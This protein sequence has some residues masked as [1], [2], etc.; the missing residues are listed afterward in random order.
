MKIYIHNIM[1][2]NKEELINIYICFAIY[3]MQAFTD[4]RHHKY[5]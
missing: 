3:I 5:V 1:R 2:L 4:K